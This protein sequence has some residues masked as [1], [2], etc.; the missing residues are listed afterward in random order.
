[1]PIHLYWKPALW[2]AD[3]QG[4]VSNERSPGR[5]NM[6]L[7]HICYTE[8]CV[9]AYDSNMYFKSLLVQIYSR[10][11]VKP[12]WIVSKLLHSRRNWTLLTKSRQHWSYCGYYLLLFY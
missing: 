1:L 5:P 6:Q 7:F 10:I 9:C 8:R 11:C 2:E 4:A 3:S 12:P